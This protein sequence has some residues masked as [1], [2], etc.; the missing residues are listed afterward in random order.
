MSD[1]DT[2]ALIKSVDMTENMQADVIEV[3][4]QAQEQFNVEKDIAAF[5]KKEIDKKYQPT[6]HCVVG[7]NFGSYV[8]HEANCFIYFYI[9]QTA[10]LLFKAG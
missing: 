1:S 10:I 4:L 7:R 5:I 9:K 3:S 2:K 8:T 6:W